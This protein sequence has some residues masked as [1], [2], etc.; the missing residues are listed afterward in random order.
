MTRL[1]DGVV[2][3]DQRPTDPQIAAVNQVCD[4][5]AKVI[6]LWQALNENLKKQNPLNLP[7]ATDVPT[8]GCPQ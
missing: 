7:I 1:L 6:T 3:A 4:S 5:F 2:A 8:A